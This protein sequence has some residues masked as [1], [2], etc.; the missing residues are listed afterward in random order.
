LFKVA[1][2]I[3]L[4]DDDLQWLQPD[5]TFNEYAHHWLKGDTQVIVLTKGEYGATAITRSFE[6]TV[7]AVQ[8]PVADTVGAGDS[9]NAGL[10]SGLCQRG[11]LDKQKLKSIP[12]EDLRFAM[13]FAAHVS[14]ITVSRPGADPPWCHELNI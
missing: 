10:L 5:T 13:E 8:T 2:I 9:F 14:A 12:L 1:D 7:S 6:V 11:Y 3:K 4:S